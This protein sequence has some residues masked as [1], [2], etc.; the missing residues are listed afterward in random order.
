MCFSLSMTASA[1]APQRGIVARVRWH[2][3]SSALLQSRSVS[4]GHYWSRGCEFWFARY[5]N[6]IGGGNLI[7]S[8][9][10]AAAITLLGCARCSPGDLGWRDDIDNAVVM[11]GAFD[12]TMRIYGN[13]A[14][15]AMYPS[16]A[17]D[18]AGAPLT[19]AN[20]YTFRFASD[21]LPPVN[22]FWA[23]STSCRRACWWPTHCSAT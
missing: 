13:T 4:A 5:P 1:T 3:P 18:S 17:N 21:H 2:E 19:G 10:L 12:A 14:A 23:P 11:A 22:A 9:P 7:L 8:S 6:G 20:N 16:F 15:E